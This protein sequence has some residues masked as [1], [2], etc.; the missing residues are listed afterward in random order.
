[1]ASLQHPHEVFFAALQKVWTDDTDKLGGT[2]INQ[3]VRAFVREGTF[4]DNLPVPYIVVRIEDDRNDSVDATHITCTATLTIVTNRNVSLQDE[5]QTR[6]EQNIIAGEVVRLYDDVD[7]SS[8]GSD[9][10][11]GRA[12]VG[13]GRQLPPQGEYNRFA[14]AIRA[15]GYR[16][17][18]G[19]LQQLVGND[20][21][22]RW[23]ASGT[24]GTVLTIQA[25]VAAFRVSADATFDYRYPGAKW[26]K[27]KPFTWSGTFLLRTKV[28]EGQD[29]GPF[30][31]DNT[32]AEVVVFKRAGESQS[33][34]FTVMVFRT[35]ITIAAGEM[36][37]TGQTATYECRLVS[38]VS[39]VR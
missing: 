37:G 30:I 5:V 12:F 23:T 10:L 1:M 3:G 7:I 15:N 17:G 4:R 38:S 27:P 26:A 8:T 33:W 24:G 25:E 32:T 18:N 36:G 39:E 31:P 35:D 19:N 16:V 34:A 9:W 22:I 20:A 14:I 6:G 29:S 13:Q 21:E 2:I 11:F 28:N